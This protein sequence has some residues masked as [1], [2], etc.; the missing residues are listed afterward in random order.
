MLSVVIICT[1]IVLVFLA[2]TLPGIAQLQSFHDFADKRSLFFIHNAGDVL[3]N[4]AFLLVA[5][6][7]LIVLKN[8]KVFKASHNHLKITYCWMFIGL[9]LTAFG[10]AFYHWSPNDKRLVWDRLPMTIVFM[11]LLA[12]AL[13][14][15]L[16]VKGNW[17]LIAALSSG[18]TSVFYW[19]FS[20]NLAPYFVAQYGAILL[21]LLSI[22]LLPSTYTKRG[23]ILIAAGFLC[24]RIC[25]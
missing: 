5:V 19:M 20:G 16:S 25:V 8:D 4:L 11:P 15:R 2:F 13:I 18:A 24:H 21:V 22:F 6:W 3:S 9:L 1:A 23:N 14:E 10:S 17:L 12:A 7:G